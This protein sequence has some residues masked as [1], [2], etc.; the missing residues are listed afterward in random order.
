MMAYKAILLLF[1][2]YAGAAV[3]AFVITVMIFEIY[4]RW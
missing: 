3:A 2:F 1:V 4:D